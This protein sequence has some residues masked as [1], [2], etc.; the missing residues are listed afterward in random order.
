MSSYIRS[1]VTGACALASVFTLSA[2]T[3]LATDGASKRTITMVQGKVVGGSLA[4]AFNGVDGWAAAYG[5]FS[6]STEGNVAPSPETPVVF[7]FTFNDD[8]RPGEDLGVT[9]FTLSALNNYWHGSYDDKIDYR[10]SAA[11]NFKISGSVDGETWTELV[12]S[13]GYTAPMQLIIPYAKRAPYRR[14]RF[15]FT[16]NAGYTGT[17]H[18]TLFIQNIAI[19]ADSVYYAK[20]DGPD[21]N[22]G[23]SWA[24]ATS[25]TNAFAKAN[26]ANY[27]EVHLQV[28]TYLPPKCLTATKMMTIVGGL[29]G[30]GDTPDA[31]VGRSVLDA[32]GTYG[33]IFSNGTSPGNYLYGHFTQLEN[34]D[35][36]HATAQGVSYATTYGSFRAINCRFAGNRSYRSGNNIHQGARGLSYSGYNGGNMRCELYDCEFVDNGSLAGSDL[37]LMWSGCGCS[38][39]YGTAVLENCLFASNGLASADMPTSSGNE[40]MTGHAISSSAKILATGCRFVRNR[41]TTGW[42]NKWPG[43]AGGATVYS[44]ASGNVFDRCIFVA[45]ENVY[46]GS[47]RGTLGTLTVTANTTVRNCTFAYNLVD[48]GAAAGGLTVNG[49]TAA[50]TNSIFYGNAV[51]SGAT[52]GADIHVAAAGALEIDHSLVSS[53]SSMTSAESVYIQP[54][55]GMVYDDARFV[56]DLETAAACRAAS[57]YLRYDPAQE[58]TA[59]NFDVHLMTPAGYRKN[60][61]ATWYTDA[62]FTSPAIDAGVGDYDQEPTPN[63][64]VRNLGFYGNTSEASKTAEKPHFALGEIP[65]Q[66][67]DGVNPCRPVPTITNLDTGFEIP[68]NEYSWRFTFDYANNTAPGT[69]VITVT[70]LPDGGYE[71]QSISANFAISARFHVTNNATDDGTGLSWASP[72]TL[73]KAIASVTR[74]TDE[75]LMKA[76]TYAVAESVVVPRPMTIR[77]GYAGTDDVTLADDPESVLDGQNTLA[78]EVL[79]VTASDSANDLV[80]VERLALVRGQKRGLLKTGAA[81]LEMRNCRIEHNRYAVNENVVGIGASVSG[82]AG[83]TTVRLVDCRV[84]DNCDTVV[85]WRDCRGHGMA[86]SNLKEVQLTGCTFVSNGIPLSAGYNT[87]YS[88]SYQQRGFAI[89]AS[90]VPIVALNCEFRANRGLSASANESNTSYQFGGIV[91]LE[92]NGHGTSFS[93]CLFAG[94]QSICP[95]GKWV[96]G[97]YDGTVYANFDTTAR[98]AAFD[99][100]T[101]LANLSDGLGSSAA[102]NLRKGAFTVGNSVFAHNVVG[103]SAAVGA[104]VHLAAGTL[105]VNNTIFGGR[106]EGWVSAAADATI[107]G[108]DAED[109]QYGDALTVSTGD[110]VLAFLAGTAEKAFPKSVSPL[111]FVNSS[112]A[113]VAKFVNLDAHLLSAEGY[114]KNGS[115]EWFTDTTQVSPAIDAAADYAPYE[116]EPSPNGGRAN[117][118]FYGNT[119]EAAKT[120]SGTVEIPDDIDVTYPDGYSQPKISFTLGGEGAYSA[121]IVVTVSTNGTQ[122]YS[123]KF[124]GKAIGNLIEV[125][126]PY[127]LNTGV[128]MDVH[129][130]AST[131]GGSASQDYAKTVT[132]PEPPWIGKKGPPNVVHVRPGATG[133]NDGS[134]WTDAF[135]DFHAAL[136][137]M[138]VTDGKDEIWLAGTNV[139]SAPTTPV[140]FSKPVAICGGF[141]GHECAA[142][143][144]ADGTRGCIDGNLKYPTLA[145]AN[146]AS[147]TV[148]VE[149]VDFVRSSDAGVVKTGAGALTMTD[150]AIVECGHKVQ[151]RNGYGLSASGT[152]GTTTLKL[153]RCRFEANGLP[154]KN[155]GIDDFHDAGTGFG[156]YLSG[157]QADLEDCSFVANGL[158]FDQ[159]TDYT[160]G[161]RGMSAS[162][163]YAATSTVRA[164]GCRFVA[165]RAYSAGSNGGAVLLGSGTGGS[166]FENCLWC[167][168]ENQPITYDKYTDGGGAALRVECG[169]AG[170][171]DVVNCTFAANLTDVRTLSAAGVNVRSGTVNVR[172]CVFGGNLVGRMM[173]SGAT[174]LFVASGATANVT[175][176]LFPSAAG[177]GAADGG[178][179]N[180]GAGVIYGDARFASPISPLK[181][182][183]QYTG[184]NQ[185]FFT[186]GSLDFF[187]AFNVHLRGKKGYFDETLGREVKWPEISPAIDAGDPE[188]PFANEPHPNGHCVNM[189]FYG[190]TPYAT[191]CAISGLLITVGGSGGCVIPPKPRK[192]RFPV[193]DVVVCD[194]ADQAIK[195]YH[196]T[197]CVW[198]WSDSKYNGNVAECKPMN[199]NRWI[200]VAVNNGRWCIIDRGTK[201]LVTYG[202]TPGM[203]HSI[204][205]LPNDIVAVAATDTS[206]DQVNKGVYLF[207]ISGGGEAKNRTKFPVDNPH[208]FHWDPVAER[209]YVTDTYR[210]NRCIVGYAEGVFSFEV[211]KSWA[212]AP[213]GLTYVHDLRPV[214][215]TTQLVLTTYEKVV[216]FDMEKEAWVPE[217][218][219]YCSDT[220]CADP[221]PDGWKLLLSIPQT[222]WITDTIIVYTPEYGFEGYV[223]I[224]GAKMYKARWMPP[225]ETE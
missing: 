78:A 207:D 163:L 18:G 167:G 124:V 122:V 172:N 5:L 113:D 160:P 126:V 45:N 21:A 7:D 77:G 216:Y 51:G 182:M 115:S 197:N 206:G 43:A 89:Y 26:A 118:G 111:Y 41:G 174:D 75:I 63:G 54:G 139:C 131:A 42:N 168:N 134:S 213:M 136:A 29:A 64:G 220:K 155:L 99:F 85:A 40:G 214:V 187:K 50:V 154:H 146:G 47:A 194:Q 38:I 166:V 97:S 144:R 72:M 36:R 81:S 109:V 19:Y 161:W 123:E 179:T 48:G 210:L 212:V 145:F 147:A 106:G 178:V 66:F 137:Q 219:F 119:A 52:V 46:G 159:P 82:T 223:T 14:F 107:S 53:A 62:K 209:L 141:D 95:G 120:A 24:T 10:S 33:T 165:N 143:E 22:D 65:V 191:K 225:A 84:A 4:N 3:N 192:H 20:V 114:R 31:V 181:Y 224:P 25:L 202:T 189:G 88:S 86:F 205:L 217:K 140:T 69:A 39:T 49:G 198:T 68:A 176:S 201:E 164:K 117:L 70:G 80:T 156:A 162:A 71:G 13:T 11:S 157:V 177:L 61:D 1:I 96:A 101:F 153:V 121:T 135:T 184:N 2:A 58:A 59:A 30:T 17:D 221:A 138:A 74:P 9:R 90:S 133:K 6:A 76:G 110:E 83:A 175:Y 112:A 158:P 103:T 183:V 199:G 56:T 92:G 173:T 211:E 180:V 190:N 170:T 91:S 44:T 35:F 149:R 57:G 129:V 93:H 128:Q 28:G 169:A 73:A 23:L 16:K 8:Y 150:C 32:Q 79:S 34:L 200:G 15:A 208:G 27:N 105:G 188:S 125:N 87:T 215:G 132:A 104:D 127:Y 60:G 12:S 98:T 142:T 185:A 94:N 37:T 148:T 218:F 186:L 130:D 193:E 222:S 108:L 116:N 55:E 196:G 203:P 151:V 67:Y 171:V 152:S 195:I 100:C 204:E 102:L